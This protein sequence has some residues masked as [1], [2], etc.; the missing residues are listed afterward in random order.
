MAGYI[1]TG[2]KFKVDAS[3][4]DVKFIRRVANDGAAPA[5]ADLRREQTADE[6][7]RSMRRRAFNGAN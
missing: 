4:L 6:L 1:E 2:V 5:R 7:A 3:D